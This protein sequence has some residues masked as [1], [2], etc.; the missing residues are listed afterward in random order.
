MTTPLAWLADHVTLGSVVLRGTAL[1][2]LLMAVLIVVGGGIVRVTGSGLGCPDWPT[3]AGGSLGPTPEMGLHA[4]VEFANRLLTGVLCAAVGAVII[5]ARL[6]SAP[7]PRLTRWAWAQ[8]WIVVLNAVLG[9]VTV[10][11]R[12]SP[13]LVAAHFVAATALLTVATVTWERTR[14]GHSQ[15]ARL[16]RS[17]LL[18]ADLVVGATAVV[19]LLGTLVTGTGPHAGDSADVI[20]MPFPWA[21]VTVLHA[22]AALASLGLT[23]SLWVVSRRNRCR[24]LETR[25]LLFMVVFLAQGL[26]GLV[27]AIT[28]LPALLV[29]T[30]LLGSTLVWIGAVRIRSA[31]RRPVDVERPGVVVADR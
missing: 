21:A 1:V 6:Q 19:V 28:N 26:I 8:F 27:Q 7:S 10:L 17:A 3:C 14:P 18:L 25:V 15:E 30:H 22:A 29:I 4:L 13:Y 24:S 31:S 2:S 20:R 5:A 12:L 16:P 23:L 9:G 11:A